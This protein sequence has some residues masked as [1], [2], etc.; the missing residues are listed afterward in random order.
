MRHRQALK[1]GGWGGLPAEDCRL[2]LNPTLSARPHFVSSAT[3]GL[4]SCQPSEGYSHL[5]GEG[6]G[7]KGD[8]PGLVRSHA[9]PGA[10]PARPEK[11]YLVSI[12]IPVAQ[13][14]I[15]RV[16]FPWGR[17]AGGGTWPSFVSFFTIS[18]LGWQLRGSA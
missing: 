16:L 4:D 3:A 8:R 11:S 9:V 6:A 5:S 2:G 18:T 1:N 12:S 17:L 7:E 13:I 14:R 15:P 10:P